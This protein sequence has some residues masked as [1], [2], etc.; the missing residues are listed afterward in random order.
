MN[1][2]YLNLAKL[3]TSGLDIETQYTLPLQRVSASLPGTL[4]FDVLATYIAH[5]K[6]VQPTGSIDIA[7]ETGCSPTSALLC[8]PNW[9]VDL[10]AN[11]T[12][13]RLSVT[14]HGRYISSGVYDVSLVGPQDP[15]YSPTLANSINTNRVDAAFYLDLFASVDVV[16]E[17]KRNVQLFAGMTNVMNK[18]P[19]LLPGR[20][21]PVYFD[22]VGRSFSVGI[23]TAL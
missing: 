1:T 23:R 22:P 21:N 10:T 19:P 4:N 2:P 18:T 5:L 16:K 11:Y 9:A 8:V 20:G 13:K 15:G 3:Q 17:G 7:G 12:V 6:T 14:A